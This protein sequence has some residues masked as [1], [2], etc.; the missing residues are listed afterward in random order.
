MKGLAFNEKS[1]AVFLPEGLFEFGK[2]VV[3]KKLPL[4]TE[5]AGLQWQYF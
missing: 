1:M 3:K 2:F 5:T 4:Q